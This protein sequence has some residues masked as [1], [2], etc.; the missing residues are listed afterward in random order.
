MKFSDLLYCQMSAEWLHFDTFSGLMT[1]PQ[2]GL[3]VCT[4]IY[5][6]IYIHIYICIQLY[7]LKYIYIYNIRTHTYYIDNPTNLPMAHGMIMRNT[8]H[9]S[10]T[11]RLTG[12]AAPQRCLMDLRPPQE[13]HGKKWGTIQ[14]LWANTWN[15]YKN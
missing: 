2:Y 1:S 9:L 12:F 8:H 6:Y 3:Y 11:L 13:T 14:E 10:Q 7:I 4:C 15:W 5:I